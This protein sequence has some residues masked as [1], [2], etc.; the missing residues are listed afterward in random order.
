[1]LAFQ[2]RIRNPRNEDLWLE[3]V[4]L[5]MRAGLRELAA[6]RLARAL[7]EWRLWAEAIWMEER[8]GRRSKSVDALKRCEHNPHVLVAAARLFWSERKARFLD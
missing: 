2:A 7:Q 3:S 5:E 6:E 8:H 1:M 4:R